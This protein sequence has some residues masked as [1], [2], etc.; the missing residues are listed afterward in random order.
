[1]KSF[2]TDKVLKLPVYAKMTVILIGII[3]LISILYF[4]ANI[5]IP[6][7]FALI[8]A[9]LLQPVVKF[10]VKHRFNR[11]LA[12]IITLTATILLIAG[13]LFFLISQASLFSKSLPA[14]VDSVSET[15]NQF[16]AWFSQKSNI[17]PGIIH[18][19]IASAKKEFISNYGSEIGKTLLSVGN[20]LIIVFLIPVYIF[21]ILYY[22]PILSEF[23]KKLFGKDNLPKLSEVMIKI[24]TLVQGYLTGLIIE[25]GIV[26]ALNVT[27]L[28]VLGIEYA[29]LL[30]IIGGLLNL[31]PYLGGLVAVA[32]PMMVALATKDTAWYAVYVMIGYYVIQ[33][34][35]N[36]IVVPKIMASK[37]KINA[38][39]TIMV[40]IAGNALWGISGMFLAIPI[41]AII[42]LI[43]D[44]IE[45]L[46]P[47]GFLL[48]DTMPPIIEIKS[49]LK[50]RK[51]R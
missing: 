20:T 39:F 26:S 21:A 16:L 23:I 34:L 25:I 9:I 31:I 14:I 3:A 48:G 4:A 42:K 45:P 5:I 40:V 28:L 13:V 36:N 51:K 2:F 19:Q 18:E 7:V 24:K 17:N 6:L 43:F 35:D 47:W 44:H 10:L 11:I 49:I 46:K 15:I 33:L 22:E 29:F 32:L 37:V 50:K 12:I 8:I 38:L 27:F 30:G 41:L 1:M